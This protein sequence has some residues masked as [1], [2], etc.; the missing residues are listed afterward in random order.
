MATSTILN[1]VK[2]LVPDNAIVTGE[3]LFNKVTGFIRGNPIVSTAGVSIA[4]SGVVAGLVSRRKKT[5]KKKK[6]KT[7]TRKTKK[8]KRTTRKRTTRK[9]KRKKY[10]TTPRTAGKGK[11]RSTKRIRYTKK[12]QPY[13]IM[14]S[15][16]ARFIKKKSA[17]R[18]HRLKGG[19][20]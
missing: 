20:Y 12:G 17:K 11:D 9:R 14:R 3:R 8:K 5:T 15:G 18:S 16:K 19:R 7:K 4:T 10:R 6:S 13:V 1:R 2:G